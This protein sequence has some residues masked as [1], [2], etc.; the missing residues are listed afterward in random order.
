MEKILILDNYDSFTYN[1]VHYVEAN[2]NFEVDVFRNDEISLDDVGNYDT[3]I[4]SPGPGLPKDAGI[5]NELIEKYA[6]TKKILGVCLGMQAIGEVFGGTLTNLN[7][8]FHGV[9]T[10]I[11]VLDKDDLLFKNL[12][13]SFNIGRYH[14][15]VID[16]DGFPEELKITSVE[17]NGQ[18]MSLKHKEFNVYG[19]QFHPESILTEHGKEMINNFLAI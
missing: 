11:E 1:L 15:W 3:I 13:S 6:P 2:P 18:I 19:V 7:N 4:L 12:P 8:V 10:P 9:A 16:N 17:E 14:S 5:L